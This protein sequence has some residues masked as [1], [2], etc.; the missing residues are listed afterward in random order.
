MRSFKTGVVSIAFASVVGMAAVIGCSASGGDDT[1]TDGDP[2]DPTAPVATLPPGSGSSGTSGGTPTAKDAGKDSGKKPDSGV[3]AGPPPPVPGDACVM[4]NEVKTKSC[5]ICGKA[6][7]ICLDDGTTK[8]WSDYSDCANELVGGC[9]PGTTQAC[10]NCGMNTCNQFCAFTACTGQPVNSCAPGNV[11]LLAAGCPTGTYRQQE[12]KA[13]CTQGNASLTC[14][15]PPTFVTVPTAVGGLTS[16]LITLSASQT[17]ASLDYSSNCPAAT[18]N[19]TLTPY[20]YFE[21]RN[22][23]GKVAKVT[24]FHS[25]ATG[26]T[27]S[28]TIM[29]AYA[30]TTPPTTA[31]QRKACVAGVGDSSSMSLTG[32]SDFA[33]LTDTDAVTIPAGESVM[34]YSANYSATSGTLGLFK[35]NVRTDALN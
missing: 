20:N 27:I 9:M 25:Q 22:T 13:D 15:A 3:D 31:A 1:T 12:C 17:I 26:G 7:T 6:T 5:G 2:T 30:G 34:I 11:T 18:V 32:D 29:A 14:D 21:V 16:S 19:T 35:L 28:D 8:K 10:G 4:A 23:T 33:A 24:V